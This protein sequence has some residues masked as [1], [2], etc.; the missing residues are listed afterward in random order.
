GGHQAGR[1]HPRHRDDRRP[2]GRAFRQPAATGRVVYDWRLADHCAAGHPQANQGSAH[3]ARSGGDWRG[4]GG[5]IWLALLACLIV[6]FTF[7]G[8]EYGVLSVNRVRLRHYARRGEEAAQKLDSLLTRIERLM[9]TVV[10]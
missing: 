2:R 7:S 1:R 10:V 4:G 5:M 3:R 8:I 9:V 6:S